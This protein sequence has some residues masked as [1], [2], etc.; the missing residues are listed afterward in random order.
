[1]EPVSL[2][3]WA[4]LVATIGMISVGVLWYGPLFGQ[5]WMQLKGFTKDRMKTMKMTP[6]QSMAISSVASLVM[7]FVMANFMKLIGVDTV[8]AAF[9]F[10]FWAWLG[11]VVSTQA[12]AVLFEEE[13]PKVFYIHIAHLFVAMLVASLVLVL[14]PA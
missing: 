3:F 8:E 7:V 12:N 6:L 10:T 13:D 14:W 2:N 9:S 4:L 11:F 1:M 5:K